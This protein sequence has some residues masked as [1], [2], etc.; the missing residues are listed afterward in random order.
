M[1]IQDDV[2]LETTPSDIASAL[3]ELNNSMGPPVD[4]TM[5]KFKIEYNFESVKDHMK[6]LGV[7]KIFQAGLGDF[8][9]M[10]SNSEV[11]LSSRFL[12]CVE[13]P[14]PDRRLMD[15]SDA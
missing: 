13:L 15:N 3:N 14:R 8:S 10:F 9:N 5:P 11:S 4:L 6:Q 12:V 7:N 1:C 2:L